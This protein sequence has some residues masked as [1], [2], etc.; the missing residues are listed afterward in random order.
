MITRPVMQT[1]LVRNVG[2]QNAKSAMALMAIPSVIAPILGPVVGGLILQWAGWQ[3]LFLVNIPAC[4]VAIS[5]AWRYLPRD[6]GQPGER[7]DVRGLLLLSPGMALLVYG[8]SRLGESASLVDAGTLFAVIGGSGMVGGFILHAARTA[9]SSLV[10]LSLFRNRNFNCSV[11]LLL[12][13]S[14]AFFGGL[15]LLP[16]LFQQVGGFD[17]V[18]VGLL[19]G[20]QGVGALVCPGPWRSR[21]NQLHGARSVSHGERR[22]DGQP[23]ERVVS[24][25]PVSQ[26]GIT[27]AHVISIRNSAGLSG[28]SKRQWTTHAC[29]SALAFRT[30]ALRSV[31]R[32]C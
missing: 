21:Q 10:D 26:G 13:S 15:V 12:F 8:I 6:A 25:R 3:W 22:D 29:P 32:R 5:A 1:V 17:T 4:V 28:R 31:I 24:L 9:A 18:R 2:Q 7:L 30:W 23:A 27:N 20:A 19:L 11:G 16:L 14:I